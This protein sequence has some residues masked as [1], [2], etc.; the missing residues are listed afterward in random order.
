LADSCAAP[1]APAAD[2]AVLV[3]GVTPEEALAL[4]RPARS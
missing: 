3:D 1:G 2:Q 4:A